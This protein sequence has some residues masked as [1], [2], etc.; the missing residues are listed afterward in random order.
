MFDPTHHFPALFTPREADSHKGSY[1]TLAIIGGAAGM[2]GA[3]VLAASAALM[4]GCG[5]VFAAFCQPALPAPWIAGYPEIMLAT[6]SDIFARDAIDTWAIGCGL[7]TDA[8]AHDAFTRLIQHCHARQHPLLADADALNLLAADATLASSLASAQTLKVLTPHP[9]EAARL[10]ATDIATIQQ[11]REDSA[12]TLASRYRAWVVLKGHRSLI[13]APDGTL[14]V[15]DSGNPAL[16]TAGS[17]DVLTG[18]IAA[19]LAQRLPVTEAVRGGVWL[20][21]AASDSFMANGV[22]FAGLL[23]GDIAPA[24]RRL[25]QQLTAAE[26]D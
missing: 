10:L 18:M 19:F 1:G 16:A 4:S 5:R 14:F 9:G 7:G 8:A 17:G 22:P 21:G 6:A 15:N 13:A 20:H 3:V 24:A 11:N 12:R 23:A 2:S 25:R 26:A